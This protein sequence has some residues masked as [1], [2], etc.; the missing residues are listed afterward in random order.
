[1]KYCFLKDYFVSHQG[2]DELLMNITDY[3]SKVEIMQS[4]G[5]ISDFIY[6]HFTL[7]IYFYKMC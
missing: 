2:S 1:M 6:K 5:S 3:L 7:E 4:Y